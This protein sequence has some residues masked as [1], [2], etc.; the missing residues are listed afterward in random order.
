MQ[1][2]YYGLCFP[3]I[4]GGMRAAMQ[5]RCMLGEIGCNSVS[6]IFGIPQV[7]KALSEEGKPL[8]SHMERSVFEKFFLFS[9]LLGKS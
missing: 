8:D 1:V 5:L 2:E 6:N 9:K 7:H 4:Y 3:G